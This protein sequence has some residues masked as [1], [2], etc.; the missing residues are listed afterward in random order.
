MKIYAADGH[1]RLVGKGWEIRRYLKTLLERSGTSA[2][3]HE[4]LGGNVV[5]PGRKRS[6]KARRWSN[7]STNLTL[8][9]KAR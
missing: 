2:T 9:G 8:V 5:K 1:L 7:L 3:L 4:F 6:L